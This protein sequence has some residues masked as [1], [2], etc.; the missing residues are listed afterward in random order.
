MMLKFLLLYVVPLAADQ[1]NLIC[2]C[3]LIAGGFS[4]ELRRYVQQRKFINGK[5]R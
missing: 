4:D 5:V 3:D 2:R 1:N